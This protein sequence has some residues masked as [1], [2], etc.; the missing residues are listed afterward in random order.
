MDL[1][2]QFG[3][4]NLRSQIVTLNRTAGRR[5]SPY[6]FTEQVVANCD[7]LQKLRF[8]PVLPY[9]FTEHGAKR[10]RIGFQA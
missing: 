5:Y 9:A 3:T 8:S 6:V 10:R 2:C 4:S 1:R 7:H